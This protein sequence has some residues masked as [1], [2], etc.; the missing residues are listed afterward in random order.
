MFT[1]GKI[2]IVFLICLSAAVIFG[3][4]ASNSPISTS[5]STPIPTPVPTPATFIV[6]QNGTAGC[7]LGNCL[8]GQVFV[9]P[10]GGDSLQTNGNNLE[11]D[12][13]SSSLCNPQYNG[14]VGNPINA[15][16]FVGGHLQMDM[17]LALSPASYG[18]ISVG[19][20]NLYN[21]NLS[22]LNT[23]SFTHVLVPLDLPLPPVDLSTWYGSEFRI[24]MG[25]PN[26][27]TYFPTS[28]PLLYVNNIEWIS[29]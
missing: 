7:F 15:N 9:I 11:L 8:I 2:A 19:C 29:N 16:G 25:C 17:K 1:K 6:W 26:G 23:S 10:G 24:N 20:I 5:N 12:S 4:S 13:A 22:L 28:G 18:G 3:C 21:L 14:S 27:T